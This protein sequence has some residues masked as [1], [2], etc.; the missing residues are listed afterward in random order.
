MKYIPLTQEK[1]AIVNDED[2]PALSAHKWYADKNRGTFYA[3][4]WTKDG[5]VYMHRTLLSLKK[6]ELCDHKNRD[7]LD[8]RR[9]N[10]RKV[11]YI[12]NGFN[13]RLAKN[14]TSG[15]TGV[16]WDRAE[17]KWRVDIMVAQ[18][19]IFSG[20]FTDKTKAI[21]ARKSAE[22]TYWTLGV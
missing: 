7:G 18:K 12:E 14:N 22:D 1:T 19:S 16:C 2:Y 21:Q 8:N 4:R 20:Y 3:V 9:E 13:R 10:L 5:K 11:S 17:N 15:V 6:G